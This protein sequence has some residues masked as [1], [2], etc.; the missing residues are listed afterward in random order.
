MEWTFSAAD[1]SAIQKITKAFGTIT[2]IVFAIHVLRHS[3][4]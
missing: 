4:T 1:Y 2:A 3:I